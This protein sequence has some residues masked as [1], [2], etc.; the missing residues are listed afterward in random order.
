MIQFL[1][2]LTAGGTSRFPVVVIAPDMESAEAMGRA[3]AA[4][5]GLIYA[6]T[7]QLGRISF[8]QNQG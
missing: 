6:E 5:S 8:S 2:L 3:I 7:K 1:I 4:E